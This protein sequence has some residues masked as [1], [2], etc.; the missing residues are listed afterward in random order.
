V[1]IVQL[2]DYNYCRSN[3]PRSIFPCPIPSYTWEALEANL[4]FLDELRIFFDFD[5]ILSDLSI[6][7]QI[8]FCDYLLL[9]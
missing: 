9:R 2:A 1:E 3:A 5:W 6:K 8:P 7:I 4:D